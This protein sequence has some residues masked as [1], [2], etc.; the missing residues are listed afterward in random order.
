[1]LTHFRFYTFY[2]KIVEGFNLFDFVSILTQ[3]I[4]Q[5]CIENRGNLQ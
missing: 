1:M 4:T 2:T 5:G 3:K